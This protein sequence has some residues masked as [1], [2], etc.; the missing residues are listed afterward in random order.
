MNIAKIRNDK[1]MP[2]HIAFIIDGNGRWAKRKGLTRSV[3]H[4][5]GFDNLEKHIQYIQELGIKNLSIYCFSKQNWDRPK[6]EVDY[7]MEIFDDILDNYK[8]KYIDKDVRI[9]ISGDVEDERIPASTRAK[10]KDLMELT[11]AKTGFILN[12]CVNYGGREEIL[13]AVNEIV[14]SG[15]KNID[16]KTFENH[17]YTAEMLPVDFI[18]RTSGEI[19]TSNFLPWQ[20]TYSEWY[21]PKKHWPAFTKR[22]LIK[23]LKIYMKRNR[24]FGAIKG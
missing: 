15:E 18:I 23:A 16:A 14:E 8:Q 2:K 13:K 6:S 9:I 3:G 1:R 21:F 22:D 10:A 12:P 17:L 4:K 20:S 24:R 5:F 7:L 11:K 19:R